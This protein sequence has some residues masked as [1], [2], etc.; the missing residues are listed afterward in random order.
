MSAAALEREVQV[1]AGEVDAFILEAADRGLTVFELA[2]EV[3]RDALAAVEAPA[4]A[5]VLAAAA[6]LV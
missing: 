5:P 2:R 1:S 4:G 6:P 3:A